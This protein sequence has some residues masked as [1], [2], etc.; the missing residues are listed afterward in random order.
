MLDD[1]ISDVRSHILR[2]F[3]ERQI[4]LR[5]GGEVKYYVLSTKLQLAVTA[6]FSF[7]AFWC[8]WTMIS[9]L[10]GNNPFQTSNQELQ[11]QKANFERKFA[12]LKAKQENAQLMLSE[13]RTSFETMARQLEQ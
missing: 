1:V 10:I 13:Q 9:L 4:Y 5:S 2:H 12:D 8:L 11:K 3:P 7:M 6:A